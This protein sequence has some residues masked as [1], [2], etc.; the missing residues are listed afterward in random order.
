MLVKKKELAELIEYLLELE[1]IQ[2]MQRSRANWLKYGDRNT[3]FF[4]AFASARRKKNFV[5]RLKDD[6][7]NWLE[8]MPEL[9]NHILNYFS[10]LFSSEVQHT[11]PALLQKVQHKVSD[12]MN[13]FLM[14]PFTADDVK[15]A[16]FSIGD[17]KAPGPDGLHAVFFKRYWNLI[18]EEITLEVLDAINSKQIPAE[19]NDTT[20]VM[21]PK[22]DSPELVTQFRPISLCNVLYKIISKMLAQRLKSI[23]PEIISPTQSAF[24]P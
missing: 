7:G 8:G 16:V 22:I 9:N 24:V 11:D 21:I 6:E 17:F 20:V 13:N 2:V 19:W 1:E 18:G 4:Q 5:K 15:K 23:L 12:Q 14:A 3:G 10:H